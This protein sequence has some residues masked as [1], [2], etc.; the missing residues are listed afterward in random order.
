MKS[1]FIRF[2]TRR[3]PADA[4]SGSIHQAAESQAP[5]TRSD[6]SEVQLK[7]SICHW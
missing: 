2:D 3:I 4:F 7:V 5:F 1:A 6:R